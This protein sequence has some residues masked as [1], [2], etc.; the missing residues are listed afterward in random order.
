MYIICG[1]AIKPLVCQALKKR[2]FK[3][4]DRDGDGA[5]NKAEMRQLAGLLLAVSLI[6][7][8]GRYQLR[9]MTVAEA[10]TNKR[11]RRC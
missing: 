9:Q 6:R 8:D 7:C 1:A 4:C 5:L 3:K 10:I 11:T 2:L